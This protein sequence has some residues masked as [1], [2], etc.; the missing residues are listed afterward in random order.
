MQILIYTVLSI[1]SFMV[2]GSCVII[3]IFYFILFL[4]E[5]ERERWS[6]CKREKGQRGRSGG[7]GRRYESKPDSTLSMEL[8]VELNLPS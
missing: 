4:R 2:S 6:L 5:R 8:N 1:F 3:I 7:R